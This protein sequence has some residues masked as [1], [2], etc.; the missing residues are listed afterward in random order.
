MSECTAAMVLMNLSH[1]QLAASASKDQQRMMQFL[2]Q[3]TQNCPQ[4]KHRAFTDLGSQ[5]GNTQCE[6]F[7]SFL[8]LRFHVKSISEILEG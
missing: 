2:Q 8:P 6:N 4:G 5:I 7:M 1:A 3:D